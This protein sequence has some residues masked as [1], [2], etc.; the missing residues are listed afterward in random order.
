MAPEYSLA[1]AAQAPADADQAAAPAAAL[2]ALTRLISHWTSA[3][4]QRLVAAACGITLDP[5][6]V[7]ALYLLGISGGSATPSR[8]ADELQLSRPSTSKLLS[9]LEAHALLERSASSDRRSVEISLSARGRETFGVL[10]DAGIAMIA[11]ATA[12]WPE[13]ERSAFF[14]L[15]PRFAAGLLTAPPQGKEHS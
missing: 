2:L 4:F 3:D 5:V 6:A 8:I 10:F 14:S 9:R 11:S 15:L 13:T 12:Q 7:R 1:D